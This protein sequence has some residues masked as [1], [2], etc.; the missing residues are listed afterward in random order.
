MHSHNYIELNMLRLLAGLT[1][2]FSTIKKKVE[3]IPNIRDFMNEAS[4][5]THQ[6]KSYMKD[7]PVSGVKLTYYIESYGCQMNTNDTELV[8][9]ILSERYTETHDERE[10]EIVMLNTCAIRDSAEQKIYQRVNDFKKNKIVAVLGC[11][12]ERVK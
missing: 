8:R 4:S 1:R 11:M 7:L 6:S 2:R 9:S 12:A 10:A 5:E 3:G